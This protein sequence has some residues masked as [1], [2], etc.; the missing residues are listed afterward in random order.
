LGSSDHLP[1]A[2]ITG[3]QTTESGHIDISLTTLGRVISALADKCLYHFVVAM[4]SFHMH[5]S[6]HFFI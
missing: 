2:T 4:L 1:N 5:N 3:Q 6:Y